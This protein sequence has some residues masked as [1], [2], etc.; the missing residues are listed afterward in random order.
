M[1]LYPCDTNLNLIIYLVLTT[2]LDFDLKISASYIFSH[3]LISV[4][5]CT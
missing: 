4:D 1:K 5:D 3:Y 2:T